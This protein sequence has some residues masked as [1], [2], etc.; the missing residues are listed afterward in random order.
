MTQ[1][2]FHMLMNMSK[3]TFSFQKDPFTSACVYVCVC[4][5]PY[6]RI[7]YHVHKEKDKVNIYK[8]ARKSNLLKI[9]AIIYR[10]HFSSLFW[11]GHHHLAMSGT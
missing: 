3:F 8:F 6:S 7:F 11:K 5:F 1:T 10:E 9:R 2:C 4:M